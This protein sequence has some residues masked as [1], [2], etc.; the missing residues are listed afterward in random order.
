MTKLDFLKEKIN[1]VN[2]KLKG[3]YVNKI[4]AISSLDYLF[5]P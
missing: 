1:T 3:A 5:K 4:N 2:E